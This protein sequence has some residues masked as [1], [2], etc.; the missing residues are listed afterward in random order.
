MTQ[1]VINIKLCRDFRS[2][3]QVQHRLELL[4]KQTANVRIQM[5]EQQTT[6]FRPAEHVV[7]K[8]RVIADALQRSLDTGV[9]LTK[10]HRV[11]SDELTNTCHVTDAEHQHRLQLEMH[12]IECIV[13]QRYSNTDIVTQYFQLLFNWPTFSKDYS[14][15]DQV[16]IVL[17]KKNLWGLLVRDF[18]PSLTPFLSP[19]NSVTTPK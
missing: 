1:C 4:L 11:I 13:Q 14:R 19:T 17:S 6:M 5:V 7:I 15:L 8:R 18:F 3:G 2:S 10:C 16:S 9:H 12:S